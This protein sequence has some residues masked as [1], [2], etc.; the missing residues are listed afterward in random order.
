MTMNAKAI[1]QCLSCGND[2]QNHVIGCRYWESKSKM[3]AARDAVFDQTSKASNP[4]DMIGSDKIPYHLWPETATIMGS[5]GLLDGALK[6][7]RGNWREAGVKASI[8]VDA[9]RRHTDAW[10]ECEDTDPDSQLHHFCHMLACMG[11]LADAYANDTL[12]DDRQ[13]NPKNGYR[14]FIDKM[15]EHVKRLKGVHASKTPKHYTIADNK[16]D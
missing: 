15:T 12:I 7:G 4:K 14:R 9:L 16:K 11:I 1:E 13:F 3:A 8:Y 6:Y 5:L 10:F 2:V